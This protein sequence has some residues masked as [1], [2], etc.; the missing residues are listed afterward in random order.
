MVVSP[1]TS[2]LPSPAPVERGVHAVNPF[3][4]SRVGLAKVDFLEPKPGLVAS[5]ASSL[6][7]VGW[8]G[9][10]VGPHGSGKTTLT[11]SLARHLAP[12]FE[13][14][15]WLVVTPSRWWGGRPTYRVQLAARVTPGPPPGTLEFLEF[16][17]LEGTEKLLPRLR[18]QGPGEC[19]FV[20]GV[21]QLGR[22][23]Q[24]R[25]A[26]AT[27]DRAVIWTT[28]Q[29]LTWAGEVLCQLQPNLPQ[30]QR[31]IEQLTGG[32]ANLGSSELEQAFDSSG[33]NVRLALGQLY[34]HW[35]QQRL[36]VSD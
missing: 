14:F 5:I 17:L 13:Q 3:A 33:G 6:E 16:D 32:A 2:S 23:W 18:S 35:E 11:I 28:H 34:D 26:R 31:L 25:I 21:E 30:F 9:Q 4:V 27:V 10:V 22:W 15:S 12:H 24:Q 29:P 19:L 20:D 7:R 1:R 36:Q 8:R